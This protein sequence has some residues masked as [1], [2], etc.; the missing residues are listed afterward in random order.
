MRRSGRKYV[1]GERRPETIVPGAKGGRAA[2]S[3][4]DVN[5]YD[6]TDLAIMQQKL[7]FAVTTAGLGA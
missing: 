2:V 6:G 1:F 4:G 7:S 3:F 5:I